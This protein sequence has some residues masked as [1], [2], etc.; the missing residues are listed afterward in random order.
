MR[1]IRAVQPLP[2]RPGSIPL[3]TAIAIPRTI[4]SAAVPRISSSSLRHYSQITQ[5]SGPTSQLGH[6]SE[7]EY[8]NSAI[9]AFSYLSRIIRYLLY[10]VLALGGVSIVTFEGLHLYV[11]KVCMAAPSRGGSD[12]DDP[13]G[14]IAENQ[15][16]TGGV[17][18]GTDPRL[19]QKARH[20][21]R[22]AWICQQWGAGGSASS[23][24]GKSTGRSFHP[25]FVAARGMISQD[26]GSA[27]TGAS[28]AVERRT[29]DRGYELADEYVD[30]AIR[31]ARKK[32][33]VFPPTLSGMRP[34]GPPST[35]TPSSHGVPQGDPA[36]LD[37][38]LLKAG[39]LERI[40]TPDALLHA[41]DL[42]ETVL[43]SLVHAKDEQ[44]VGSQSRVMR[45]AGKVGD[46]SARTGAS[47]EAMS[48]W[49]WG[50][51]RAG[52]E[53]ERSVKAK[54]DEAVK[55]VKQ[56]AKGWFGWSSSDKK[57]N[58]TAKSPPPRQRS[59]ESPS[60]PTGVVTSNLPPGVL[61]A[62]VSLLVSASAHLATNSSLTA[63]TAL[64]SQAL[65]LIPSPASASISSPTS[66]VAQLTLHE[67]WLQQRA[68][69]L[70][71]HQGS[72]LHAQHP[73]ATHNEE[74]L[75]LVTS[76][77]EQSERII[78]SLQTLPTAYASPSSNAL[79]SPAKLLRRDAL[80][81]GA[82]SAYTRAVFLERSAPTLKKHD[83]RVHQLE[84]AVEGFERAMTLSALESG[85][86]K[87]DGDEVGQG[88]DWARYWRGYARVRG[89]LGTAVEAD[90]RPAVATA[91]K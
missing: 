61:R 73:K 68:A 15:G 2:R 58:P 80:L 4:S 65:S 64:Q 46:L 41:K 71:L 76:A 19:G 27:R 43:S 70:K 77:Q 67:T 1:S 84:L 20:A 40:N 51:G 49:A 86:E 10:G 31:E 24:M 14:W 79:T 83:D 75:Q 55:E 26:G 63:A 44:H 35:E 23:M 38:F 72:V 29:V 48:W 47:S 25:D 17:K 9:Y 8:S 87:K 3:R 82:E 5:R 32:G 11:E 90:L 39:I 91:T 28:G 56:E 37:L 50:L 34:A 62:S 45:L 36:V 30:L 13:Y 12:I 89:K 81:T 85:V 6:P 60:S 66:S 42:Y 33:L 52:V 21:L 78:S 69:L 54:I 59:S 18:G 88:E 74:A 7:N 16:W 57:P 22:G 53:M